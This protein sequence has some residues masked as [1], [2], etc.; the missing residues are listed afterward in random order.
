MAVSPAFQ[1]FSTSGGAR[2][3]RLPLE[4]FPGFWA[5]AYLV[6][7]GDY[8]V[9]I[10]C[11]SGSEVSNA[12]L[13]T[14]LRQV[15]QETG[16]Q[17][18]PVDL[19]HILVTHGHID[20]FGGLVY[21]CER[22]KAVIGVHELDLQTVARHE[23]RLVVVSHRLEEYLVE[24]GVDTEIR[25][26]MLMM[27]KFTKAIYHS[28][29]VDFTYAT[30]EMKYGPFEMLHVPGHCPGH[31][32]IRLHDFVFSG[33]H[34][35]EGMTTHQSPEVLT[36]YTGVGHYLE[37]LEQFE[38][39]A[40]S[41]LI[42]GGH[43][44]P[45][46]DVPGRVLA[47]RQHITGRLKQTLKFL[48]KPHTVSEIA[49]QLY[50]NIGGYNG[51]LVMEKAGAYVEYLYQRGKLEIDNMNELEETIQPVPIYY[52]QTDGLSQRYPN[53]ESAHVFI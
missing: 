37:S 48:S 33:D 8:T 49:E 9:L 14:G 43:N 42:L 20:H 44:N 22:T 47:I 13:E 41:A 7:M 32:A 50:G 15:S 46:R 39:W 5:Y 28:C 31:V 1:S 30:P 27:Y 35:L 52:R 18:G 3:F 10:D 29:P 21:L 17:I 19:T 26:Q 11:G 12:G 38:T 53:K 51:L 16:R 4:A 23:E 2:I 24:A 6:L 36:A 34:I 45:V 40:G 25:R